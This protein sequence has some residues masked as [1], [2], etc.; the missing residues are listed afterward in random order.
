M[1]DGPAGLAE[2]PGNALIIAGW[3]DGADIVL[4]GHPLY[5]AHSSS[6]DIFVARTG[7]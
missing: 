7:K 1:V 2:A 6:A 4:D 3:F 5:N